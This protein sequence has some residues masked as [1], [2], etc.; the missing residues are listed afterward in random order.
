MWWCFDSKILFTKELELS[1]QFFPSIELH[2][3]DILF[4]FNGQ[5]LLDETLLDLLYYP[6]FQLLSQSCLLLGGHQHHEPV[7]SKGCNI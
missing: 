5:E 6:N 7:I 4:S 2:K 1:F 3:Y